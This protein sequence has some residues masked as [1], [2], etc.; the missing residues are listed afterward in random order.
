MAIPYADDSFAVCDEACWNTADRAQR[1][2]STARNAPARGAVVAVPDRATARLRAIGGAMACVAAS[3]IHLPPATLSRLLAEEGFS[4]V[5]VNPC[6]IHRRASPVMR[7]LQ[8]VAAPLRISAQWLADA[9]RV[10]K[11]FWLTAVRV[12]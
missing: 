1:C 2:A 7:A 12:D 5:R 6:V 4:V 8:R 9:L 10:R 3:S 11:E